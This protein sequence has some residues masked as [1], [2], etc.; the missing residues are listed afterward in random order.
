MVKFK[1]LKGIG[2]T[3]K[4]TEKVTERVTEKVTETLMEN[5]KVFLKSSCKNVCIINILKM[6]MMV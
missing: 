2:V 1:A 4:V 5:E 3:K 6:E